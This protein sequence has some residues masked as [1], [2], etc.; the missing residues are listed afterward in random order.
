MRR[1]TTRLVAGREISERIDGRALWIT[2]AIMALLV[3]TGVVLPGLLS[4]SAAPTAIGLVG[5]PAQAMA[6]SLRRAASAAKVEVTIIDVADSAAARA[7]LKDG[8]LDVALKLGPHSATAEVKESLPSTTGALLAVAIDAAHQR[9]VLRRAGVPTTTIL[10]V[11]TPVALATVAIQ[12]PPA[13]ESARFV[14]ALAAGLALYVMLGMYGA[15][16]ATGV[17]QEKTSRTAEVLLAAVRPRQLLAG[18]VVGIG[19]CG[20]GQLTVAAI[21][22]LLANALV[23]S[24]KIPSTVWAVLPATL[25]WF[26]LGYALYAF[27]YAAAGATVARQEEVQV[28]I[29][30]ITFPLVVGF[31]LVYVLIAS[32]HSSVIRVLSFLPP[33]APALIPARIAL[34]GVAFWEVALAVL[35]MLAT[36]YGVIRLSARIYTRA[37]VHSGA[38][39]GFRAALMLRKRPAGPA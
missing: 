19:A 36:T 18:K 14:A 4:S 21:A 8:S 32:P 16:I 9:Q 6:P 37:L 25:L 12:P 17:A 20:L 30:P 27:A 3:V 7:K 11:Q 38:R 29:G 34:G 10:A 31:L 24:V 35:I 5:P 23:H 15:A 2:T 28:A 39:L 33:L 22:G 1:S 26:T 13:D